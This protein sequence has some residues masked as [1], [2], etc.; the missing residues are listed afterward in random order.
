MTTYDLSPLFRTSVG[1]DR[2]SRLMDAA[3]QM[4]GTSKGYPPYNILT[5]GQDLYRISLAVAGFDEADL[6]IEL[7]NNQLKVTRNTYKSDENDNVEYLH[8][9]LAGRSFERRFQLA[10][11]IKVTGANLKNGL[12]HVE[13]ERVIPEALRPRTIPIG[14][15][16]GAA[17]TKVIEAAK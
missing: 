10:D 8:K 11:H 17:N 7:N 13:L 5:T 12:L 16:D 9:G 4:E 1:F 14:T 2:L 6:H 15:A 3:M